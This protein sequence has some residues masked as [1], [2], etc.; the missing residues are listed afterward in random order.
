MLTTLCV[1]SERAN[2]MRI[3]TTLFILILTSSAGFAF[4]VPEEYWTNARSYF[5]SYLNN[6][7]SANEPDS[8]AVLHDPHMTC[9]VSI[10]DLASLAKNRD[11]LDIVK[12]RSYCWPITKYGQVRETYIVDQEGQIGIA[13]GNPEAAS[14]ICRIKENYPEYSD[15]EFYTF[16]HELAPFLILIQKGNERLVTGVMSAKWGLETVPKSENEVVL[17]RYEDTIVLLIQMMKELKAKL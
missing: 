11:I 2:K 4:E 17:K 12:F 7:L 9:V 3:A 13:Y 5:D 10:S 6:N 16:Q 8:V 15:Y 1:I 14:T